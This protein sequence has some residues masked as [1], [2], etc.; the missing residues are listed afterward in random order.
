MTELPEGVIG[1]VLALAVC[2][3]LVLTVRV[4]V[5]APLLGLY[6]ARQQQL[7]ER[8]DLV[9]RLRRS[10]ADLPRLR[11][12]ADKWRKNARGGDLLLSGSSDTIAAATLQTS[13]KDLVERGGAKLSSAEVLPAEA[14]D[15]FRKVGVRVSFSGDVPLLTTVLGGIETSHP[16][17]FVENFDIRTGAKGAGDDAGPAHTIALDVYG[18]RSL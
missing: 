10:A 5:V 13:L 6:D 1:K 9:A 12:E 14:A 16:I 11:A 17:M 3:L 8:L 4:A 2:A 7:Q 18:F 15:K